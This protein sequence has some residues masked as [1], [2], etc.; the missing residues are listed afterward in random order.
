[1]GLPPTLDGKIVCQGT[2]ADTDC[3]PRARC[4]VVWKRVTLSLAF[5]IHVVHMIETIDYV[6][7]GGIARRP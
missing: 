1:V 6:L 3:T 2:I 7:G 4:A 5:Y